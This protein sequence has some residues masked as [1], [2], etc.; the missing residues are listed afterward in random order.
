MHANLNLG[1]AGSCMVISS[2]GWLFPLGQ[3]IKSPSNRHAAWIIYKAKNAQLNSSRTT[4][5]ALLNAE[6]LEE[7]HYFGR[8]T[9]WFSFTRPETSSSISVPYMMYLIA[10][11]FSYSLYCPV[12]HHG[13]VF[14]DFASIQSSISTS[15]G[16]VLFLFSLTDW[17]YSVVKVRPYQIQLIRKEEGKRELDACS[18]L[19]IW[20]DKQTSPFILLLLIQ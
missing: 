6:A 7:I 18:H 8:K 4:L 20:H 12:L 3:L 10:N 11:T 1:W 15:F 14:Y 2:K 9:A 19:C 13:P 5:A 17:C 16:C